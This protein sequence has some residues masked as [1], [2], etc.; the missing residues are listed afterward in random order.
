[1]ARQD[2]R[3]R[4]R[5][6]LGG[7]LEETPAAGTGRGP[8]WPEPAHT[9]ETGPVRIPHWLDEEA[10]PLTWRER[11]I[12]ERF[13]GARLDTGRRAVLTMAAVGLLTA[14]ITTVVVLWERPVTQPV[15]PLPAAYPA[16]LPSG[17]GEAAVP[18][19]PV[20]A[21]APP[22]ELVVSVVGLV[23]NPGLVR[24][25]PGSRVA[26]AI[27]AAG[28]TTA[29]ADPTGLNL[30]QR[31]ADGD[32]V[33]VGAADAGAPPAGSATVS[34]GGAPAAAP[35]AGVAG[36]P[37]GAPVNLNIATE[38]DLDALPGVGPVTAKAIIAWR[39]TNGRFTEVEQLGEVDGIGPA[40]LARLR[41]L[42]TI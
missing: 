20:P 27:T 12:P 4:I 6:Q 32:Q 17:S 36:R 15:P 8:Q 41:E 30:A 7:Q 33:R 37:A 25:P 40:R 19:D 42:V 24:L 18:A 38:S 1:M 3:E 22:A 13:R 34:G 9:G 5:R 28:G 23:R 16:A 35:G 31:L 10:E 14:L 29:G 11:L 39:A 2:E 26:D 21:P